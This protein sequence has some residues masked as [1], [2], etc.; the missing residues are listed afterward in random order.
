MIVRKLRLQRGWSQEQLATLTGLNV[1][2]IQRIERGQ[3]ASLESKKSFASVF[4]VELA[5]FNQSENSENESSQLSK[6]T[7]QEVVMAEIK[8]EFVS[9]EEEYAMKYVEGVKGFYTHLLIFIPLVSI[10]LYNQG[11]EKGV[12]V[13]MV[14]WAVAVVIHGLIVYEKLNILSVKWEKDLIEKKLNHKL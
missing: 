7:N 9:K 5:T 8:T 11:S 4:E 2:T 13:G 12:L 1:R 10:I 6:D 3:V 14:G